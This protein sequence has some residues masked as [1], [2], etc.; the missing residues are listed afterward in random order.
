MAVISKDLGPVSAYAVAVAN[1]FTGT[2]AEW[3]QYI[4]NASTAAQ[5]AAGS[6]SAAANSAAGAA[7]SATAAAAS[8]VAAAGSETEAANYAL[9]AGNHAMAAAASATAAETAETGAETAQA[10]AEAAQAAAEAVAESIP[11]DYTE[12][13]EE[14][15][16]LKSALNAVESL[17]AESVNFGWLQ[18][19]DIYPSPYGT[20][21]D[22][23]PTR[24]RSGYI[25]LPKGARM[26]VT[27]SPWYIQWF[28]YNASTK[29]F[30]EM[31]TFTASWTNQPF[32]L[33]NTDSDYLYRFVVRNADANANVTA[34]EITVVGQI[35]Y[36][37]ISQVKQNT[38][39]IASIQSDNSFTLVTPTSLRICG[40]IEQN[41]YYQ[42]LLIGKKV[43]D[44]Y[45]IRTTTYATNYDKFARLS[46]ADNTSESHGFRFYVYP[47]NSKRY[48]ESKALN[49]QI[50]PKSAGSGLSKKVMIIGDSLTFNQPM[51][52]HLVDN[53]LNDDVMN[54]ELIGTLGTSPYLREGRS[55]WGAYTYTHEA[56]HTN[57]NGTTFTNA[58]WN[59]ST[60][61]FDFSYY[62]NQNGFSGVDYVFICLGTNDFGR[63]VTD[64]VAD[65]QTMV[66][67]IHAYNANIR[68]GVWSPPPRGLTGNGSMVNHDILMGLVEGILNGFEGKEASRTYTVPVT[69]NVD[70][71][72][73]FPMQS[74]NV[75]AD[76]P[77]YQMLITTDLVHPSNA[78]YAKMADM[79][80]SYIKYFGSLDA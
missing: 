42:N 36:P 51:T 9:V 16:S 18:S 55:G 19:T 54:V 3:E 53:L 72:Y 78:G 76:N 50:V 79:I 5:S 34:S 26:T 66:D 75:S 47:Y 74:V 52:K 49:Y 57:E 62:M 1:G 43:D 63:T 45:R 80:Y 56:E 58:F 39:D 11:E 68:V 65:L 29:A 8:Q 59:P 61:S 30:I 21:R 35:E 22:N 28:K 13:T 33:R 20:D 31:S 15:G 24:S 38:D 27:P 6:A 46:K 77:N 71:F 41:I 4:A 70:P 25:L 32:T 12:L 10:A 44:T 69:V 73:D 48:I 67:S 14:V 7:Q 40:G 23:R 64:V 17:G 2:E 60:L 37:I